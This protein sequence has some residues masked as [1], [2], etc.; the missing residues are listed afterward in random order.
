VPKNDEGKRRSYHQLKVDLSHW[1]TMLTHYPC[2]D[3]GC[4][5]FGGPE[6][7][8]AEKGHDYRW[9][10]DGDA[11]GVIAS[12]FKHATTSHGFSVA[13][14]G[15]HGCSMGVPSREAP[16]CDTGGNKGLP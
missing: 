6:E 4:I 11:T 13:D 8:T 15:N 1:A 5:S 14:Q 2:P 9:N 12:I 10:R 16:I 3:A 7:S